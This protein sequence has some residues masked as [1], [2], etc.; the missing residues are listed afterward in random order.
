ML[1]RGDAADAEVRAAVEAIEA[2]G[3]RARVEGRIAVLVAASRAA[4]TGAHLTAAG[5]AVLEAA[6]AALTER[7][8]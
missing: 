3:A 6:V 5:R 7:K 4:Q 2:C 8:A 1:G